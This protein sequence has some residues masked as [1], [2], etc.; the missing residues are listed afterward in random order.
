M[1][2]MTAATKT[3]VLLKD[4]C[5]Q[6]RKLRC[7]IYRIHKKFSTIGILQTAQQHPDTISAYTA[8]RPE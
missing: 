7:V 8:L 5:V 4:I 3:S 2:V 6:L 1:E